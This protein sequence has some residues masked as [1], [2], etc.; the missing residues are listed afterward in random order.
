MIYRKLKRTWTHN[1]ANY[2]PR[3]KEVFPELKG[4]SSEELADRFIELD[5]DF[6]YEEKTP[7]SPLIRI[8]MPFAVLLFLLMMLFIPVKFLFTGSWGY[9]LG[10]ENRILN[11][12]RVLKIQ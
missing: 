6:Y 3:L 8:T 12:F 10:G 11:W 7:V 1:N 4:V 5:L 2:I 9:S